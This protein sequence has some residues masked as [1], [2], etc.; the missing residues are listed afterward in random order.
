MNDNLI[1]LN[2][3]NVGLQDRDVVR[4]ALPEVAMD[5]EDHQKLLAD[6]LNAG[7]VGGLHGG[8]DELVQLVLVDRLFIV[9]PVESSKD[10]KE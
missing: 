7:K 10:G 6:F 9:H 8:R 4:E 5:G 2:L 1:H 3:H